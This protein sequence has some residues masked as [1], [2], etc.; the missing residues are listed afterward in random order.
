MRGLENVAGVEMF[1]CIVIKL[2]SHGLSPCLFIMPKIGHHL[3]SA[4]NGSIPFCHLQNLQ[5]RN[6]IIQAIVHSAFQNSNYDKQIRTQLLFFHISGTNIPCKN[7][8]CV[9]C[10]QKQP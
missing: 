6:N 4:I 2:S 9:A 1:V 10:I 7:C 5:S 8:T 3:S